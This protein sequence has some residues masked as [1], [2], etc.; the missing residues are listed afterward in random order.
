MQN[1]QIKIKTNFSHYFHEP[2]EVFPKHLNFSLCLNIL[3][4]D[5]PHHETITNFLVFAKKKTKFYSCFISIKAKK[6]VKTNCL[7]WI[8]LTIHAKFNQDFIII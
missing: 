1:L 5:F 6:S 8:F 3:F 4:N 2:S 7:K